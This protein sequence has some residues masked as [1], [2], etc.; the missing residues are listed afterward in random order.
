MRE[1]GKKKVLK[2]RTANL[3]L[4]FKSK[5]FKDRNIR[6]VIPCSRMASVVQQGSGTC[7]AGPKGDIRE[8]QGMA[9]ERGRGSQLLAPIKLHT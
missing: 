8:P 6:I 5:F 2:K 7:G 1:E 4:L 9:S 3:N